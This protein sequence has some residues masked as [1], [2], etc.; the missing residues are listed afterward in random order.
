MKRLH[1]IIAAAALAAGTVVALATFQPREAKFDAVDVTGAEWG[2]DFHLTGHDGKPRS[3]ADFRGKVVAL[4]FGYTGCP[5]M[6]P[7]AMAKLGEAVR[8]LGSD[9]EHVQ[10]LF[11]TVDPKRDTPAVL[12]QYV[13]SF[14]PGFI[15]LYGTE[16]AIARTAKDFKVFFSAQPPNEHGGYTVDHSGYILVF[17]PAGR[18]RLVVSSEATAQSIAHDMRLLLEQFRS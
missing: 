3:L 10:G 8:E 6:C 5:D 11:V 1:L 17:D 7:T 18:L 15:G 13:P 4:Y 16:N 9:G 14:H 12:A 2:K